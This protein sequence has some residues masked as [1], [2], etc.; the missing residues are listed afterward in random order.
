MVEVV[1]IADNVRQLAQQPRSVQDRTDAPV[2]LQAG[3]HLYDALLFPAQVDIHQAARHVGD[4]NQLFRSNLGGIGGGDQA[5]HKGEMGR[6]RPAL[7]RMAGIVEQLARQIPRGSFHRGVH[8]AFDDGGYGQRVAVDAD[9]LRRVVGQPQQ[10][11]GIAARKR[12][13]V[14]NAKYSRQ[15]LAANLPAPV[16]RILY[17]RIVGLLVAPHRRDVDAAYPGA[18]RD[19]LEKAADTT[20][21]SG[22]KAILAADYGNRTL[23]VDPID[24]EL[25]SGHC[26]LAQPA[27][28]RHARARVV[29]LVGKDKRQAGGNQSMR[30]GFRHAVRDQGVQFLG[31]EIVQEAELGLAGDPFQR[32]VHVDQEDAHLLHALAHVLAHQHPI[33]VG[34]LYA[35]ADAERFFHGSCR[36]NTGRIQVEMSDLAGQ[37]D[38]AIGTV[39]NR[40]GT[41]FTHVPY[42]THSWQERQS[43]LASPHFAI[44]FKTTL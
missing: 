17:D 38:S 3:L 29:H 32:K 13:G 41:R 37:I 39:Y 19:S 16:R 14:R 6:Q 33:G 15:G 34:R 4:R 7:G 31:K 12:Q 40:K 44:Q 23:A 18:D 26:R 8:G 20:L 42:H 35:R 27:G 1:A 21:D 22:E 28:A 24:Q 36:L 9:D 25:G 10:A 11:K 43:H 30:Q 5:L 2:Q